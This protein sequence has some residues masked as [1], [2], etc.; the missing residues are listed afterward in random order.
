VNEYPV[1]DTSRCPVPGLQS[2]MGW[3][4]VEDCNVPTAPPPIFS[5]DPVVDIQPPPSYLGVQGFQGV[6]GP[7]GGSYQGYQGFQGLQGYQGYQGFQGYQG[8]PGL[9]CKLA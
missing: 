1:F 9:V 8:Y 5:C 7:P 2:V 3:H 4:L 6:P